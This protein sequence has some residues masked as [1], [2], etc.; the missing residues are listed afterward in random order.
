MSTSRW[1]GRGGEIKNAQK[2]VLAGKELI[3]K[4]TVAAAYSHSWKTMSQSG[5]P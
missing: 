3:F 1:V 4:C 5:F 2:N